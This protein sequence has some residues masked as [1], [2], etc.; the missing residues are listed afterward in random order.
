MAEFIETTLMDGFA[1]GPHVTEV[2]IGLANQAVIGPDDYVLEGGRE[3]EA[4][5]LTNNSIRIFDA[6]VLHTGTQRCD[7]GERIYRCDDCERYARHEPKRHH[8]KEIQ[9]K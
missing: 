3:S 8:C 6:G 2:Q 4:Q 1:D 9:K 5:V 7:S